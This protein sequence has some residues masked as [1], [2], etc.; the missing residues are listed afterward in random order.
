MGDLSASSA[1]DLNKHNI[2][3]I[4]FDLQDKLLQ[5]KA[6]LEHGNNEQAQ[7]L[8]VYSLQSIEYAT[9]S[10]QAK[11]TSLPLT[12]FSASAV[13]SQSVFELRDLAKEYGIQLNF[14]AS[15]ALDLVFTNP[16]A[17]KGLMHSLISSLITD[18]LIDNKYKVISLAV[19]QTKDN[20]QRIGIYGPDLSIKPSQFTKSI[21][22]AETSRMSAPEISSGS[23]L[24]LATSYNLVEALGF[25]LKSF[26]HK[27]LSGVGLY[28]PISEQL[29]LV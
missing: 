18:N 27:G 2:N 22:L 7:K 4:L 25:Q 16:I 17:L 5:I 28:V 10:I 12:S 3:P 11:Q 15:K 29:T 21:K 9:F 8:A 26:Q 14:E 24:G 1:D 19:Q 13:V 23:G 6:L 20:Y